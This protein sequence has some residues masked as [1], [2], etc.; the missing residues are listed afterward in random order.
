MATWF[1][2]LANAEASGL[3]QVRVFVGEQHA[4]VLLIT[5][6]TI[7]QPEV[8]SVAAVGKAP[9]RVSL[10]FS[11]LLLS[12]ELQEAYSESAGRYLIPVGRGDVHTVTLAVVGSQLQVGIE[13]KRAREVNLTTLSERALLVDI[14]VPGA[15]K[16]PS[17]PRPEMLARW[18][19][20]ASTAN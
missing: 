10:L 19:E 15:E 14:V 1:A 20:G 13:M 2:A 12:V 8:R 9:A 18:I 5:D 6:E 17:L 11:N 7:G 16:D 4:Q 3:D